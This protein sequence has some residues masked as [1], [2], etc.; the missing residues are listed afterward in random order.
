[1]E[2]LTERQSGI[3]EYLKENIREGKIPSFREIAYQFRFRG[4]KAVSDHLDALERKGYIRRD[5]GKARSIEVL[6]L[7]QLDPLILPV[8]GRIA[9]GSPI[10]AEENIEGTIAVDRTW[11]RDKNSFVLKVQGDSMIGAGILDGDYAVIRQD[12]SAENGTIVAVMIDEEVTLKRFY[13]ETDQITLKPENEFME[14]IK[15]KRGDA[16][17]KIIGKLI[18]IYRRVIK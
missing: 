13:K 17:I 8:I 9:A 7:R 10:L 5:R 15:I 16:R 3:L 2:T 4:I 14:P 6:G 12:Y 18:G 1:M 11:V